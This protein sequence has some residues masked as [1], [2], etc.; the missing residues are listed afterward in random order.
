[1][2]QKEI[3]VLKNISDKTGQHYL[4]DD[5]Q[6]FFW[7]YQE[8][9]LGGRGE[10]PQLNMKKNVAII[11]FITILSTIL[12]FIREIAL[13]YFYGASAISDV[14]LI[15]QTIPLTIFALIGTGLST[16]FIPIYNKARKEK[17]EETAHDFMSNLINVIMIVTTVVV[18]LML[19]F[20]REIVILFAS[21][22]SDSTMNLAITFTRI[23][24]FGIY[25]SGL[26]YTFN[27]YLQIYNNFAIPALVGIPGNLVIIFSY[28]IAAKTNDIF[29]AYGIV[30]SLIFQVLLVIPAV[31]KNRY[32]Y[33]L[34][35]HYKDK[36]L[37][38]ILFLSFPVIIGTSVNQFN[39]LIDKNIA[40]RVAVGGISALNYANKLTTYIGVL[41]ATSIITVIYPAIS[42][43][44]VN[45][46]F[47]GLKRTIN[48]SLVSISLFLIPIT[49]GTM[50]L[51]QPIV[52]MLFLRGQFD[53]NAA[54]MTSMA[55]IG[56]SIGI[57]A[58]AYRDLISRVFYSYNDTKTPVINASIGVAINITL[59]IILARYLGIA[60][61]AL[62]TSI[63]A[64]VTMGM[65]FV[66]L[67]KKV[68]DFGFR[69]SLIK[70]AKILVASLTMGIAVFFL[71]NQL[72]GKV[73]QN[74]SIMFSVVF[75]VIVY[76]IIIYAFKFEE[77]DKYLSLITAK[78]KRKP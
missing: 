25:F 14:Y 33:K 45:A 46:N 41:F 43:M 36:Y 27:P 48:E 8:T 5:K 29:L 60:G 59:D 63:A 40:S 71:F 76:S 21:G 37:K 55:L 17:G 68:P 52:E 57:I 15:A 1:M 22:F 51:A 73:G 42:E 30:V 64:F 10:I 19:I 24:V 3:G 23:S 9:E 54:S 26:I 18:V 28:F 78:L 56:Y 67:R 47:D 11:M 39:V 58:Y 50:I 32:K 72:R 44:V 38:E 70:V 65:L 69:G 62:A 20:T 31:M 53:S 12:G 4:F 7:L 2:I 75:G 74:L 66:S 77:V 34:I 13:T 61:L 35:L 49:V 6:I 16:M